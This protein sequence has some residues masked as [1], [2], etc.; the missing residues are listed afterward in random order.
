MPSASFQFFKITITTVVKI[1]SLN[2]TDTAEVTIFLKFTILF[3]SKQPHPTPLLSL[4]IF[5]FTNQ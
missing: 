5:T 2:R 3:I 1:P 4:P